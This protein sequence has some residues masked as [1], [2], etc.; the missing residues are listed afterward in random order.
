LSE[1]DV[2]ASDGSIQI[3]VVRAFI[4][5]AQGIALFGYF[6]LDI[7]GHRLRLTTPSDCKPADTAKH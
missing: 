3:G 5:L 4:G 7:T 1:I 6:E 2:P